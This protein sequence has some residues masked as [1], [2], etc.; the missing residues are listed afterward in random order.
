MTSLQIL[1]ILYIIVLGVCLFL[2]KHLTKIKSLNNSLVEKNSKLQKKVDDFK[3]IF[4]VVKE[5]YTTLH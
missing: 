5:F 4:Q 1:G 2:M 3:T